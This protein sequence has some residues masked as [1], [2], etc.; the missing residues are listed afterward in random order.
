MRPSLPS[1]IYSTPLYSPIRP[2]APFAHS[3]REATE[4]LVAQTSAQHD[5]R[6]RSL[7]SELAAGTQALSLLLARQEQLEREK[8]DTAQRLEQ[9][10]ARADSVERESAEHTKRF[11]REMRAAENE[12]RLAHARSLREMESVLMEVRCTARF[13]CAS[14][15]CVYCSFDCGWG[16]LDPSI[17]FSRAY[18]QPCLYLLIRI[19]PTFAWI[20]ALHATRVHRALQERKQK[21]EQAAQFERE[22]VAARESARQREVDVETARRQSADARFGAEEAARHA[23]AALRAVE[24]ELT[25]ALADLRVRHSYALTRSSMAHWSGVSGSEWHAWLAPQN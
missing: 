12:M 8:E 5:A 18:V 9:M 7:E 24:A 22:A 2:P 14:G 23:A 20:H 6:V 15:V 4:R 19:P 17:I 3:R 21:Q 11:H 16:W 25:R 1:F 10:R 13:G